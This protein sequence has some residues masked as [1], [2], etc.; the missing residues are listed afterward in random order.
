M[1]EKQIIYTVNTVRMEDGMSPVTYIVGSRCCIGGTQRHN[2]YVQE[3]FERWNTNPRMYF[4]FLP[5]AENCQ[6]LFNN[7]I[8]WHH[9][10]A[11]KSVVKNL[12]RTAW[13]TYNKLSLEDQARVVTH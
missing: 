13:S 6:K 7:A 1:L 10:G 3:Y 5:S 4:D 2:T 12:F 9:S 8:Y 11:S